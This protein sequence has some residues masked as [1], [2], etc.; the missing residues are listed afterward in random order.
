MRNEF[1]VR[2]AMSGHMDLSVVGPGGQCPDMAP[3]SWPSGGPNV[4]QAEKGSD[5]IFG[6]PRVGLTGAFNVS[7]AV[8][9]C[10]EGIVLTHP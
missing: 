5:S 9:Y 1:I 7:F 6:G 10:V 4:R 2:G 8:M 3:L